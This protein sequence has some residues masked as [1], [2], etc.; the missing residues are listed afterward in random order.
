M[1]IRDLL[2][3][4]VAGWGFIMMVVINSHPGMRALAVAVMI[5]HE[6]V[7]YL[8]FRETKARKDPTE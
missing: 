7:A 6:I 2:G 1:R 8:L 3:I 5:L 4:V